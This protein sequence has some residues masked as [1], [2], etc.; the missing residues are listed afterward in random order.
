VQILFFLWHLLIKFSN[1]PL[2]NEVCHDTLYPGDSTSYTFNA[3]YHCGV[4]PYELKAFLSF[5]NDSVVY[6]DTIERTLIGILPYKAANGFY[7]CNIGFSKQQAINSLS[8]FPNPSSDFVK[9]DL[10][11]YGRGEVTEVIISN[12]FGQ[13]VQVIRVKKME[14]FIR[15]DLRKLP[16]GVYILKLSNQR[17][18]LAVGKLIRN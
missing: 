11:A 7:F 16:K 5:V 2:V 14:N 9:I 17:H 6:N 3:W 15:I 10:S 4:G 12:L 8:I 13:E 18:V 1:I